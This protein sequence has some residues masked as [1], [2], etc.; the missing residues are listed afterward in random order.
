MAQRCWSGARAEPSGPGGDGARSCGRRE[1]VPQ[2]PSP[3]W[4]RGTKALGGD[5]GANSVADRSLRGLRGAEEPPAPSGRARRHSARTSPARRHPRSDSALSP[6]QPLPRF[7][8]SFSSQN[9]SAPGHRRRAGTSRAVRA[10]PV[11][12]GA[13]P[14]RPRS[15]RAAHRRPHR[16]ASPGMG[17]RPAPSGGTRRAVGGAPPA[18]QRG[19]SGAGRRMSAGSLL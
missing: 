18:V 16:G 7:S 6:P 19:I 10:A 13:L 9:P 1:P 4:W 8:L 12:A 17:P 11:P 14:G 5:F 2:R 3:G 15:P